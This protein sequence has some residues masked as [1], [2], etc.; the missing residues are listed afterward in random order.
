MRV[1]D[2]AAPQSPPDTVLVTGGCGFIGA[3]LVRRLAA[4]GREVVV[5][6]D[7]STGR[8]ERLKGTAARL[9]VGDVRDRAALEAALRGVS[10]VVHLAAQTSLPGS[11]ADPAADF[12]LNVRGAWTTLDAARRAGVRTFVL[13][14]SGAV[15]G[16][17]AAPRTEATVPLPA[18][19]YGAG[20]LAAEAYCTAYAACYGMNCVALRLANVYG[21]FSD[22]KSSVVARFL[23]DARERGVLT[24][25]GTG[26]QTRDFVHAGDVC[27]AFAAALDTPAAGGRVFQ[28]G[29]GVETSVLELAE[30]L[31]A[32]LAAAGRRVDI[33]FGPSRPGD[34]PHGACRI[35][36][37]RAVLGFTPR[38]GLDAGLAAICRGAGA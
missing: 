5:L 31:R 12:D 1:G 16:T 32:L 4:V 25:D 13:A 30:R 15:L 10:A 23:R 11:I 14:S 36:L 27:A 6:D 17:A 3:N 28:I 38:V 22:G 33:R 34:V 24:V 19:P 29:S 26:R 2:R 35:D 7:L 8:P 18:T 21:P 9:R 20:K 37:A